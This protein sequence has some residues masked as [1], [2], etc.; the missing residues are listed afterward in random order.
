MSLI[1]RIELSNFL[2]K[3]G[4]RDWKPT[5]R[6]C[7]LDLKGQNTAIVLMNGSGKTTITTAILGVLSRQH[8]L[9]SSMRKVF[10]PD[11]FGVYTHVRVEFIQPDMRTSLPTLPTISRTVTGE[12]YVFGVC[13]YM[14]G[15]QNL[16]YY[17]YPGILDDV[18]VANVNDGST[19]LLFNEEFTKALREKNG[20]K[21]GISKDEWLDR[22]HDH[23]GA[24]QLNQMVSF[25]QDGGG[26]KS[27]SLYK[28]KVSGGEKYHESFFYTH[29]APQLTIGEATSETE[30][31]EIFLDDTIL[32]SSMSIVRAQFEGEK[33]QKRL[34][35]EEKV[36]SIFNDIKRLNEEIAEAKNNY[37]K[38]YHKT[39]EV[40]A[41]VKHL[42]EDSPLPGL[43]VF[44]SQDNEILNN[45]IKNIV[46]VPDAAEPFLLKDAG[47]AG[48]IG[49]ETKE[50]NQTLGSKGIKPELSTQHIEITCHP[51]L[52]ESYGEQPKFYSLNN[53]LHFIDSIETNYLKE[54][55]GHTDKKI[56]KD[57]IQTAFTIFKNR[58]DTSPLRK[59]ENQALTEARTAED[60]IKNLKY[61]LKGLEDEKVALEE[62]LKTFKVD[63]IAFENM[64]DSDLFTED[65]L[66]DPHQTKVNLKADAEESERIKKTAVEQLG[67]LHRG[68]DL[69]L[70]FSKEYPRE[71]PDDH[72]QVIETEEKRLTELFQT[73]KTYRDNAQKELSQ[74]EIEFK[75]LNSQLQAAS[76]EY[77]SIQKV[78]PGYLTCSES[79]PDE[80]I[81]GFEQRIDD[82]QKY[83]FKEINKRRPVLDQAQKGYSH[84]LKFYELEGDV[85]PS[86]WLIRVDEERARLTSKTDSVKNEITQ[87]EAEFD[88]LKQNKVA[89]GPNASKAL[90]LI[91][92]HIQYEPLHSFIK[93]HTE[94][95]GLAEE[96][97]TLFSSFLF[98]PVIQGEDNISSVLNIFTEKEEDILLPVFHN[99]SLKGLLQNKNLEIKKAAGDVFYLIAG[100]KTDLIECILD[101]EKREQ[102]RLFVES[103]LA[104]KRAERDQIKDRLTAISS[105]SEIVTLAQNAKNSKDSQFGL[106]IDRITREIETLEREE[107]LY[108]ERFTDLVMKCVKDAEKFVLLGGSEKY[109]ELYNNLV[110][111]QVKKDTLTSN[112]INVKDR[113]VSLSKETDK[114]SEDLANYKD[115][116]NLK[117]INLKEL[118]EFLPEGLEAYNSAKKIVVACEE[119]LQNI[120]DK[121]VLDLDRAASYVATLAISNEFDLQEQFNRIEAQ[122][123]ALSGARNDQIKKL[124]ELE[125][126]L[127]QYRKKSEEY[128]RFLS[129]I[130][131]LYKR[132]LKNIR[133]I[134]ENDTIDLAFIV[135]VANELQSCLHEEQI[136]FA[137]AHAKAQEI[138]EFLEKDNFD[139]L[140]DKASSAYNQVSKC[141][142]SFQK[143]CDKE[144]KATGVDAILN[145]EERDLVKKIKLSPDTATYWTDL[146]T[147][148]LNKQ[149]EEFTKAKEHEK[150]L[151][152]TLAGSLTS[153]TDK[154]RGNYRTLQRVL[155]EAEGSASYTVKT[156]TA[157][158]ENIE[159]AIDDMIEMVKSAH[160]R[161]IL[162]KEDHFRDSSESE[163]NEYQKNLKE[164]ISDK[165]YRSI[166]L[167]PVIKYK[168]PD[169]RGGNVTEFNI[170]EKFKGISEG[171][172]TSLALLMQVVM[173]RYAQRRKIAEEFG[174]GIRR[175]RDAA[176]S[177][178]V[179]IIDGLFSSLSKPSL[180]KQAFNSI[181][182]TQGA[183]QI[184]GLIHNP[185]YVGT[186]DF[187]VFPNLFIGRTYTDGSSNENEGWVAF[188]HQQKE[189]IGQTGF[190]NFRAEKKQTGTNDV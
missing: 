21:Q 160:K 67:P 72:L 161:Y 2:D 71:H 157:S 184:I 3:S 88:L 60:S 30:K 34:Q 75:K 177:P 65:E 119:K 8:S 168:H 20:S 11:S 63:K 140:N 92:D 64:R 33:K 16:K 118:G 188:D 26:D 4:G 25:L 43:P 111:L 134:T 69:Y 122:R 52:P 174:Q 172:K 10:A 153:L 58:C 136:D 5:Y 180:I 41:T 29:I 17:C 108:Q 114:Y 124:K 149:I 139:V 37:K 99:E 183:F 27:A 97:L 1:N 126:K 129:S 103:L 137:C 82:K 173:A 110:L 141:E 46:I 14:D 115:E 159:S 57:L 138:L 152:E 74:L 51:A 155:K 19:K 186:H 73:T 22:V 130:T 40:A 45:L 106:R 145:S 42:V 162:D 7:V 182:N 171:E 175:R 112:I 165:C 48:L 94:G 79:F 24:Q 144:I 158:R 49:K 68:Y 18:P 125:E 28:T 90:K 105:T 85:D 154:A 189:M 135:G 54:S 147:D 150:K 78:R 53:V 104:K 176:E 77:E 86:E 84:E 62:R 121:Q 36:A 148:N 178:N 133:S 61:K 100:K 47:L 164:R 131:A 55:G 166:F 169:I 80:E 116:N 181:K 70:N 127:R 91:P 117:K 170:S 146:F 187:D 23:W 185:T 93:N 89:P 35:R 107:K 128:D 12:K 179:L 190:A 156:E 163:D 31:G 15:S 102:R 96:F 87:Y 59:K 83:F 132:A 120:L 167:K 56:F 113:C 81:L 9:V 142:S 101:P 98:A 38:A 50:I 6:H 151:R 39:A 109:D 44:A 66:K 76:K 13:G 32:S 143:R 123:K 95:Q